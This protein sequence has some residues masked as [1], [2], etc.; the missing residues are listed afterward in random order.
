MEK[1]FPAKINMLEEYLLPEERGSHVCSGE[2][3]SFFFRMAF[4]YS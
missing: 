2:Y 1:S 4:E 3:K